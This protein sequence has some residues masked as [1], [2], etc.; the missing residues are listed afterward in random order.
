MVRTFLLSFGFPKTILREAVNMPIYVK[1]SL[2]HS[3]ISTTPFEAYLDNKPSIDYVKPAPILRQVSTFRE[4]LGLDVTA[5]W[6]LPER[7]WLGDYD[8]WFL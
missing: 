2:S 7:Y 3:V 6:S 4:A 5:D 8:F 1:N